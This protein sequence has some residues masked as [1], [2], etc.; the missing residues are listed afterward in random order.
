MKRISGSAQ[1]VDALIKEMIKDD[2]VA[3]VRFYPKGQFSRSF[4]RFAPL[5]RKGR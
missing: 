1:V 5:R 4:L 2:K 3:I